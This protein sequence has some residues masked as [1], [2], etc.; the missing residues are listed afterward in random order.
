MRNMSQMVEVGDLSRT[1]RRAWQI[2][3]RALSGIM[4]WIAAGSVAW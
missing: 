1:R 4:V 2:A 3:A